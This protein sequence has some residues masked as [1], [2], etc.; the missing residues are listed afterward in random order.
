MTLLEK[1]A[2]WEQALKGRNLKYGKS[3]IRDGFVFRLGFD[4]LKMVYPE[5]Q[6]AIFLGEDV[7]Q[8]FVVL[9]DS[10]VDNELRI[11]DYMNRI[12]YKLTYG[13]F[14]MD[15]CDSEVRFH[16]VETS[17]VLQLPSCIKRVLERQVNLP[18]AMIRYFGPGFK[19]LFRD[20]SCTA[21]MAINECLENH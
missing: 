16:L 15:P 11:L 13:C 1:V 18:I 21:E 17:D 7:L 19:R 14:E 3:E 6:M 20:R 5:L 2:V 8:T 10:A 9:P 12:N 4:N